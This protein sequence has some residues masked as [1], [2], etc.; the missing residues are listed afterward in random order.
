MEPYPNQNQIDPYFVQDGMSVRPFI[1][2]K[3]CARTEA[4]TDLL[5]MGIGSTVNTLSPFFPSF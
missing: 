1:Q 4:P 5:E 2:E 3:R